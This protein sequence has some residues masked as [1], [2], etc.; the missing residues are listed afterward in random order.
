[1]F[2]VAPWHPGYMKK[3]A[4][5]QSNMTANIPEI[6]RQREGLHSRWRRSL[7]PS[8]FFFYDETPSFISIF[9]GAAQL[10]WIILFSL[11]QMQRQ[12]KQYGSYQTSP[13]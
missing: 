7:E 13:H 11:L 8:F 9:N 6:N 10:L 2:S 1:M 3:K 4:R 5:K 12:H